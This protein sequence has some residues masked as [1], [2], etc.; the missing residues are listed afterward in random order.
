MLF[1]K[2]AIFTSLYTSLSRGVSTIFAN[3][4][5]KNKHLLPLILRRCEKKS[6]GALL[7]IIFL[8]KKEVWKDML[9]FPSNI[10]LC[11]EVH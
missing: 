6:A 10:T 5:P 9:S 2:S 4:L 3:A 11:L 1:Q 8:S 7:N